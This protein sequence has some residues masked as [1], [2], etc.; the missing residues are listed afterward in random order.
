[1]G[2]HLFLVRVP[3]S[4]GMS[5]S[6]PL[7]GLAPDVVC[8]AYLLSLLDRDWRFCIERFFVDRGGSL[9]DFPPPTLWWAV[10]ATG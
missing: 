7:H 3:G 4:S 5:V 8:A 10:S 6:L 9:P 2:V 1:L